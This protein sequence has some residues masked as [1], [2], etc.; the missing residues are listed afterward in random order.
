MRLQD[1][2]EKIINDITLEGLGL[3]AGIGLIAY[4]LFG[5]GLSEVFSMFGQVFCG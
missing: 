1:I 2:I 4:L 5:G 3:I